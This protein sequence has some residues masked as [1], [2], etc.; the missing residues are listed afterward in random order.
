MTE[1]L[2]TG[3]L[4]RLDWGLSMFDGVEADRCICIASIGG[5]D[6][7][8]DDSDAPV[9]LTSQPLS[10]IMTSRV[11]TR[12]FRT[13]LSLTRQSRLSPS[14]SRSMVSVASKTELKKSATA[15][16]LTAEDLGQRISN[17]SSNTTTNTNNGNGN[18]NRTV[19]NNNGHS[20]VEG[21]GD[22]SPS[23]WSRSFHGLSSQ[24]FDKDITE[25][26]LAPVDPVDIEIK[27]GTPL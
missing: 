7:E 2:D 14:I 18:G 10:S 12:S 11:A 20:W 4:D 8:G 25:I 22:G 3:R 16:D 17:R 15:A 1:A 26:L 19:N 9:A 23:D 27:P 13:A 6:G 21:S 5:R 24:P